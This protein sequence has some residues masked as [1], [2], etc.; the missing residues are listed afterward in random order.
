MS[1]KYRD[2]IAASNVVADDEKVKAAVAK[3]LADHLEEN[4]TQDVY[5]FLFNT[6]DLTTLNST[7]SPQSVAR[8]VERVNAFE[9]EYGELKNVAAICVYPCFAQVVRSVLE[10]SDVEI[11]CVSAC[12]PT[13]QSF[14][15]VKVAETALAIDGGA[16]EIDIV[17][18][19]GNYY[20]GDYEAVCDEIAELKAVCRDA[21]LKVILETGALKTAA[22]IKAASV[23]SLYS[24]ADFLKTSTGKG[25]P[26][27]TLEAAYVMAQCIKEYYEKT[28]N[29]VGFKAS[30]GVATTEDAV[31]YYT[32]IKE[33]LGEKW[34][35]NEYFR[36]GASRLAN[37]LLSDIVGKEVK[38]F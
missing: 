23:L 6:I 28:G 4:K 32:I 10:V 21:H 24:G 27:A 15:E 25:Y 30:G 19:L 35:T 17:F 8:F 14:I 36:I 3:I 22:D 20:D 11:A 33:V 12:F 31:A 2:T 9:E 13:S 34:L 5:K 26:G 7:D 38:F 29:M 1:D 37:N 18:N 16:D